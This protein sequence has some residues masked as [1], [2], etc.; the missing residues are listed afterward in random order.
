MCV[1]THIHAHTY[2]HTLLPQAIIQDQKE[3][4]S[5]ESS[6]GDVYGTINSLLTRYLNTSELVYIYE[7]IDLGYS[8]QLYGVTCFMIRCLLSNEKLENIRPSVYIIYGNALDMMV[9]KG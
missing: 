7:A 8:H 1:V 3:E 9:S 2:T 5:M 6:R 4:S